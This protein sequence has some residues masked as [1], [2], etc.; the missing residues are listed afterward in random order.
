MEGRFVNLELDRR[1][2]F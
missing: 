2:L 1:G